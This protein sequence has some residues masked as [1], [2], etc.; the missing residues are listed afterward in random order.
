MDDILPTL[1]REYEMD[2]DLRKSVC[3]I[4]KKYFKKMYLMCFTGKIENWMSLETRIKKF[5]FISPPE[6]SYKPYF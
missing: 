6:H 1:Y 2:K 3:H 5:F 4:E